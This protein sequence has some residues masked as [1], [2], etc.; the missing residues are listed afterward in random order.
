ML[1]KGDAESDDGLRVLVQAREDLGVALGE[2]P[3]DGEGVL[4]PVPERTPESIVRLVQVF[5]GAA[6]PG[7]R[8]HGWFDERGCGPEPDREELS[9]EGQVD[10][11]ERLEDTL[12][13]HLGQ[14][15]GRSRY[16]EVAQRAEGLDRS[17]EV[18]RRRRRRRGRGI[19]GGRRQSCYALDE[20]ADEVLGEDEAELE[21]REREDESCEGGTREGAFSAVLAV[22]LL[23]QLGHICVPACALLHASSGGCCSIAIVLGR[24]GAD[25]RLLRRLEASVSSAL[26]M[27]DFS[28]SF[29]D[30]G[31]PLALRAVEYKSDRV[32]RCPR[33]RTR[34]CTPRG[35]SVSTRSFS[36]DV[37]GDI[38]LRDA[39]HCCFDH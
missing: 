23:E 19:G 39:H 26:A 6:G 1:Q 5:G 11:D 36:F 27:P 15:V 31:Y 35:N 18:V 33:A 38:L 13:V 16:G 20:L 14:E 24:S 10:R 17:R 30:S 22:E 34:R 25:E 7:R 3:Q 4:R 8:R 9:E 2:T 37:S 32:Q 12:V 21:R 28:H 29:L